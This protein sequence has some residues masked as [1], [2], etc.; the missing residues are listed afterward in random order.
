VIFTRTKRSTE[1]LAKELVRDGFAAAMIHGD[2]FQSQRNEALSGFHE[3]VSRSWWRISHHV[4]C[5]G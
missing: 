1:R 2:R 5:T 3:A 4:F